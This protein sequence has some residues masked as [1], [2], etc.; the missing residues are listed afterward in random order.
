MLFLSCCL[1]SE[2]FTSHCSCAGDEQEC[3]ALITL[4]VINDADFADEENTSGFQ[5]GINVKLITQP[6]D[7]I[8]PLI[9]PFFSPK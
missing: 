7:L 9:I 4:E 6:P 1:P 8:I 3:P 2:T 5:H